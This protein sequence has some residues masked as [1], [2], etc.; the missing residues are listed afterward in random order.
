M[1]PNKTLN[2]VRIFLSYNLAWNSIWKPLKIIIEHSVNKQE[3]KCYTQQRFWCKILFC[4][5]YGIM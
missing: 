2:K 5:L 4:S 3:W 1:T